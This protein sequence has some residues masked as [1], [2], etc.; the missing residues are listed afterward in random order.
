MLKTTFRPQRIARKE[1]DQDEAKDRGDRVVDE[2]Q[3]LKIEAAPF[4]HSEFRNPH[5]FS[6]ESQPRPA[7]LAG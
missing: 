7:S 5:S 6:P 1:A 4:P 3:D 2:H